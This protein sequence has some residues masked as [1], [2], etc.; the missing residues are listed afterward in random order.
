M[1]IHPLNLTTTILNGLSTLAE[2]E[3][4]AKVEEDKEVAK[5]K[6]LTKASSK[7]RRVLIQIEA[8]ME[9][10][11]F[12][13][14]GAKEDTKII[15][16]MVW[17]IVVARIVADHTTLQGTAHSQIKAIY[18]NKK[19][20]HPSIIKM[21]QRDYLLWSICLILLLSISGENV[22]Y[23]DLG[24]SNHMTHCGEWFRDENC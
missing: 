2:V 7:I 12:E 20:M 1:R 6:T 18:D 11:T 3:A 16:V 17:I 15:K 19:T 14:G 24:A 4:H 9:E 23:V 21:I 13:E 10:E 22:W 8:H 5:A